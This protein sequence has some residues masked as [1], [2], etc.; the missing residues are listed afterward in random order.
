MTANSVDSKTGH[1]KLENKFLSII[2]L[3]PLY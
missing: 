1:I 3:Y 2:L